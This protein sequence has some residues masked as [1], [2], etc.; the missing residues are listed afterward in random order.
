MRSKRLFWATAVGGMRA[1]DGF[2]FV[3]LVGLLGSLLG[4]I[5]G[6]PALT[7]PITAPLILV[8]VFENVWLTGTIKPSR[9]ARGGAAVSLVVLA[10]V[11]A[12]LASIETSAFLMAIF[13]L[14]AFTGLLAVA[15]LVHPR[16]EGFYGP[17]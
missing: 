10:I 8:V 5:Q 11:G 9:Y 12:Q 1:A 6:H 3:L 16:A 15:A 2:A 14:L 7:L 17:A 13:T 4:W